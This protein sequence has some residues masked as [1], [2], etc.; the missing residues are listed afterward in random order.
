MFKRMVAVVWMAVVGFIPQAD[1]QVQ[2]SQ[3]MLYSGMGQ[4][5][6][7]EIAVQ[8]SQGGEPPV[9]GIANRGAYQQ[10][11][12]MDMPLVVHQAD[13]TVQKQ[14]SLALYTILG[15][16]AVEEPLFPVLLN[17]QD[18]YGVMHYHAFNVSLKLNGL[19]P[20]TLVPQRQPQ[21]R[22][23]LVSNRA[24]SVVSQVAPSPTLQTI[25][26]LGSH[27]GFI[28]DA[29]PEPVVEITP[30]VMQEGVINGLADQLRRGTALDQARAKV[31]V[32]LANRDLFN[33]QNMF[34]GLRDGAVV[35][36]PDPQ[37][38]SRLPLEKCEKMIQQQ[39]RL[40]LREP[41][42]APVVS[43]SELESLLK[44]D[45]VLITHTQTPS[46]ASGSAKPAVPPHD[47][48]QFAPT[49]GVKALANPMFKPETKPKA[50]MPPRGVE[51]HGGQHPVE[52]APKLKK[53]PGAM[54]ESP[55]PEQQTLPTARPE[56]VDRG[57]ITPKPVVNPPELE[58]VGSSSKAAKVAG[59]VMDTPTQ[60][61][62]A[63]KVVEQ[64]VVLTGEANKPVADEALPPASTLVTDRETLLQK[65]V[66]ALERQLAVARDGEEAES[67]WDEALP[68]IL[69]G[70]MGLIAGIGGMLL[71]MRMQDR[72]D[73]EETIWE[74]ELEEDE[75][76]PADKKS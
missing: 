66:Q 38:V 26:T 29:P 8:D 36:W 18:Q 40:W 63:P 22:A 47:G 23:P 54:V 10:L 13:V 27:P 51:P 32:W 34:G 53:S 45:G 75:E 12:G 60:G 37:E 20:A 21:F 44:R 16:V 59:S 46:A 39:R 5:L 73:E 48:A 49:A 3:A 52:V 43:I 2:F 1:A 74:E 58:P 64:Q 69:S 11:L 33:Q 9:V 6:H 76:L 68:W 14:G 17:Y 25:T 15:R 72:K 67:W 61:G 19:D 71:A 31:G 30:T 57:D 50:Q 7:L 56:A 28:P 41:M 35:R 70:L 24:A 65:R 62:A 42:Q 4:P 55:K